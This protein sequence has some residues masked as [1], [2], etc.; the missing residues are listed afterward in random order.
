MISVKH[1]MEQK[2]GEIEYRKEIIEQHIEICE[3]AI[4]RL[5]KE[6]AENWDKYFNAKTKEEKEKYSKKDDEY[7]Q[8]IERVQW[9]IS[10]HK[11]EV[12][13]YCSDIERIKLMIDS[14]EDIDL[15]YISY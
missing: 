12:I 13:A 1:M 7:D 14:L 2:I 10:E 11:A 5:E 3:S 8:K 4:E 15:G 6:Q 9:K